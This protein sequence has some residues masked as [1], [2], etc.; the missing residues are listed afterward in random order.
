MEFQK[1]DV[2]KTQ[3]SGD[4]S[5]T[6]KT[7][8][9]VAGM[10]TAGSAAIA[11]LVAA[12][13]A[14]NTAKLPSSLAFSTS[15]IAAEAA[16]PSAATMPSFADL[17]ERVKPAVVSVYVRSEEKMPLTSWNGN[18]NGNGG[19][20]GPQGPFKFF[21]G[22]GGNQQFNFPNMQQSPQVVRAQG[23]GFFIS[24]DGYLVTNNHV[25]KDAKKVEV[26][27][28]SGETYK[29][30]VIGTDPKTD[31]ALLKV[32]A[33]KEFPHVA[34]AS[35]TPRVGDWVIA[36]GNPFGLGGTV[37]AGIVSAQGR[38]IGSGPY[39]DYIQIDAPVNSGNSGGPSFN[40]KG[41][42]VGINTAI[43]TPSGGSVGIAFDIPAAT[44]K[45][46]TDALKANG[47]VTRGWI[48]VTIQPVTSDIA[49]SV[50]L[51]EASGAIVDEPQSGSP[52]AKAGLKTGDVI[53]H[54]NGAVVKDSRDLARKVG[55]VAPGE[56]IHLTVIHSG[57]ERAVDIVAGTYP[58]DTV[59]LNDD[60]G[61]SPTAAL[62]MTLAPSN[63]VA[64]AKADG[65]VVLGVNPAGVA[66]EKGVQQGDVITAVGGKSVTEPND[67]N[68]AIHS[69]KNEGKTAILLH[70]K[71][72]NGSRF[73]ALPLNG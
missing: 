43:Y 65:V 16:S 41:E 22:Q 46:V 29:A 66:S 20:D 49:E 23:S 4:G 38:D 1:T 21:F 6:L 3:E 36:M 9:K 15:A 8:V 14:P 33:S 48:G 26:K 24:G 5:S 72:A 54:F 11:F 37:T 39:D 55:G 64:G 32:D 70:M 47:K 56:T 73:V 7:V 51:K 53:T 18:P 71:T 42:V 57:K 34:F 61:S 10:A 62:G 25:V 69:A 40:L 17:V 68:N 59:A 67:I 27:T 52:A 50:G 63:D 13:V 35:S 2:K 31:L 12:A 19:Q 28:T 45:S 30:K 44:A 58:S 60:G